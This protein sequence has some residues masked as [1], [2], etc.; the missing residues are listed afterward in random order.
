[1]ELI[2]KMESRLGGN[3]NA[4]PKRV[5]QAIQA[6][7]SEGFCSEV[8]L[9][10]AI[11]PHFVSAHK[12]ENFLKRGI[13]HRMDG[14]SPVYLNQPCYAKLKSHSS[15]QEAGLYDPPVMYESGLI[16]DRQ[17]FT[18]ENDESLPA[19]LACGTNV[20]VKTGIA[21][22]FGGMNHTSDAS[23]F[24]IHQKPPVLSLG[25]CGNALIMRVGSDAR[26]FH[27]RGL[28]C[29]RG[30]RM[31]LYAPVDAKAYGHSLTKISGSS[32]NVMAQEPASLLEGTTIT[33][34][35]VDKLR[36]KNK[37]KKIGKTATPT[38]DLFER[39]SFHFF[40][41]LF[42]YP[43]INARAV[44]FNSQLPSQESLRDL[45]GITNQAAVGLAG[46]GVTFLLFVASR[47]LCVNAALNKHRIASLAM[48][49]GFLSLSLAM[50][51]VS[52]VVICMADDYRKSRASKKDYFIDLRKELQCVALNAIPLLV[53]CFIGAG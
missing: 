4:R 45:V 11:M 23:F 2:K 20:T 26:C 10:E 52:N 15:C 37:H 48:G 30:E 3:C 18:A 29:G 38:R 43:F 24:E 16:Y 5:L 39:S 13:I 28:A 49:V 27:Q 42:C 41:V 50:K 40:E 22:D 34:F 47:M 53:M 36:G 32:A 21:A 46:V 6:H 14:A 8:F 33:K 12:E 25:V 35:R 44:P 51:R 7:Y 9:G 17:C 31:V 19:S 1:M